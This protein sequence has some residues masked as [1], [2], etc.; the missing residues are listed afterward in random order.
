[1]GPSGAGM[2]R[3]FLLIIFSII[4]IFLIIWWGFAKDR[5]STFLVFMLIMALILVFLYSKPPVNLKDKAF[6]GTARA[7]VEVVQ[8]ALA[9]YSADSP[10]SRYPLGDLDYNEFRKIPFSL[11]QLDLPEDEMWLK[12]VPNSFSYSSR[13]GTTYVLSVEFDQGTSGTIIATPQLVLP[14]DYHDH[15]YLFKA[16][17]TKY[18]G[19]DRK[20]VDLL[21]KKFA[22]ARQ[23]ER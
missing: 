22:E 18:W 20:R 14:E 6:W 1:M 2:G 15:L 23:G 21:R 19:V 5:T 8:T 9:G 4:A 7:Y 12:W 3:M 10:T 11:N 17:A 13:D 16:G